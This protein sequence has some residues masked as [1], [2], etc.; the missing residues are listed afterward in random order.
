MALSWNEIKSRA[1]EFSKEWESETREHAEAKSFWDAFFSV[2]GMNRRRLAAFEEPVK[3]LENR[4][5]FIDLFWKGNL[6]VEHKTSGK[7][8]D[9]AYTQATDYF[10]GIKERDLPKYVLVSDFQRFRL[11][12]MEARTHVEFSLKDLTK[13]IKLFGFIAGYSPQTYKP[14]DPVNIKAAESMGALYDAIEETGYTGHEL[15]VLLVRL[16][17]CFFADDSAIFPKDTLRHYL[18]TKTN[19]D[20][21]DIGLHL[22]N[23]F[24][25]LNTSIDKRQSTLDE[26]LAA[27][28]YVN[29][30]LFAEHLSLPSFNSKI[31]ERLLD[32]MGF[33]WSKIS[34]AIFGSMFQ[35]VMDKTQRR[36]LG[37]HYTSET[38]ILKLIKPLFLDSLH[39]ELEQCGKNPKK[40]QEFQNKI[41]SLKFLDP[42]CGCGNFLVIAYRE[43]RLLELEVIKRMYGDGSMLPFDV[44]GIIKVRPEQFYG[45]EI[46]EFPARI[47]QTAL[48]LMDHQMNEL[49]GVMFGKNFA[50]LPLTEGAKIVVGNA[51]TLNWEEVV[52]KNELNYILGNPPFIGSKMMDTQQRDEILAL[53]GKEPGAGILDYVSGWYIK[54][55]Q[56]IQNTQ[57][58]VAF[59]STN[60]ITQ[61]EQVGVLWEKLL[62][63]YQV[64]IHFAHRTF[65][66]SNEARGNA[67]VFCVIIG[68][69]V[70][71]TN[72]KHLFE[73]ENNTGEA[74]VLTAKNINPYLVDAP[75]ILI[76][77]RQKSICDAPQ[78]GIGNKPIDGGHYLF[79]TVEKESFLQKEPGAEKYF[80]KWIGGEEFLNNAD[81]WC[82]YLKNADPD[83][84]KSLPLVVERISAVQK[85]RL[86]SKSKPTQKLAETPTRFHV[87][88]VSDT[89]YLVIPEVTPE[90]RK[91]VPIGFME[92]TTIASNLVKIIPNASLY[93]FGILQ[94]EMHMAWVRQIAGRLGNGIRYSK[95]IVYN[96]FP[97]PEHPSEDKNKSVESAAQAVLD[98]RAKFPNSSLADLYNPLTMPPELVSA[99]NLLN[100]VVDSLYSRKVY[101]SD[102]ERLEQLFELYERYTER[103]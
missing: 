94:S 82:L 18:E 2:F 44:L 83:E 19:E 48:W 61:G 21:S 65:K 55:A 22:S 86:D 53:F 9:A 89:S 80:R 88:N 32:A 101:S 67:G 20:G 92:P 37:A 17:F 38:N 25:I 77:S 4:Q 97:W 95:D 72:L 50:R 70:S 58:K 39:E 63:K 68:F 7:N 98:A 79:T 29:G 23:V 75:N 26:D 103:L 11:Y 49:V 36:H 42:A 78:I 16:L 73:Y 47:A 96:N 76:R 15:K 102:S 93:H 8:L 59:V 51:L 34:P 13:N 91:Y 46:E 54:A 45:I 56:Y 66:W 40:L 60:S 84:L 6:L 1:V 35:S 43:L 100:K 71:D 52:A 10:E 90:S 87:E 31:R 24:Q 14:E 33:D 30:G 99:H 74:H 62:K 28:E 27:L 64:Q 81:R 85:F 3:M 5:G 41:A 12:D 69:T 57:I